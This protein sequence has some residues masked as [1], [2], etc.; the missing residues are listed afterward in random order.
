MPPLTITT[1]E[2]DR[3]AEALDAALARRPAATVRA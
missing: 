1:V 2:I 3:F